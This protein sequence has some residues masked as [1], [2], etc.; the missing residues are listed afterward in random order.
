MSALLRRLWFT[1]AVVVGSLA[2]SGTASAQASGLAIDRF[3]P[4]PVS[5][6]FFGVQRPTVDGKVRVSGG[7]I[8]DYAHAPLVLRFNG[9]ND[10]AE[11]GKIISRRFTIHASVSLALIDRLL[12]TA[13]L[14]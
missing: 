4:A 10:D 6:F 5:D 1:S 2:S 9:T 13:D 8:F 11:V 3:D 14:P 12:F 7:F